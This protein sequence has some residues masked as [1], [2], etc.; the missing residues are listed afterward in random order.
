[1]PAAVGQWSLSVP[2]TTNPL[3]R[4]SPMM[5]HGDD[6]KLV[7]TNPID[8]REREPS[9]QDPATA[10]CDR[11]EG[12]RVAR[13]CFDCGIDRSG[14]LKPKSLCPG[15]ILG[16]CLQGLPPGLGSEQDSHQRLEANNSERTCSHG[17]AEDGSC[18][19]AS[20]RT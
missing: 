20:S 5:K 13:C 12:L 17:T 6:Q 9:K 2:G 15:L 18:S 14:E 16:L 19:W 7:A 3:D 11:N 8:H 10:H 1:M 4:I